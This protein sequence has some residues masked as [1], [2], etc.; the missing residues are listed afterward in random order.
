MRYAIL[1]RNGTW[2]ILE[3][4]G[5]AQQSRRTLQGG[6]GKVVAFFTK[7][8]LRNISRSS[9]TFESS[10]FKRLISSEAG[11]FEDRV[12]PLFPE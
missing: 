9:V 6:L 7:M 10:F 12:L 8:E 2:S 1:L 3:K 5:N 11:S 4:D